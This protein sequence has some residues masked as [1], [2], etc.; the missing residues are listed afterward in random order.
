[1]RDENEKTELSRRIWENV[2][3]LM[4]RE[5][6]KDN[7]SRLG[8]DTGIKLGGAQR[9][10]NGDKIGPPILQRVADRYGI[11]PWQ[12]L[13]PRLGADLYRVDD[14]K[15]FVCVY[16]GNVSMPAEVREL[17]P[18]PSTPIRQITNPNVLKPT[19]RLDDKKHSKNSTR[20]K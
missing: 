7:L 12:L 6:G 8:E 9:I 1:M 18:P 16:T 15:R 17:T 20:R 5:Y 4:L 10:K 11:E 13:A 19:V 2:R 14:A 3:L